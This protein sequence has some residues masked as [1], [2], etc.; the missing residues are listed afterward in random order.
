MRERYAELVERPDRIEDNLQ[1]GAVKAR[2]LS[3]PL[4]E[5]LRAAVGLRSVTV[6]VPDDHKS[7]GKKSKEKSARFVSFRDDA[8]QFRF[9]LLTRSEE[10]RV[11]KECVST[12]RF[13]WSPDHSKK[14]I[15]T[16]NY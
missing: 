12:C 7:A 14:N 11:G 8:G 10:R 6:C 9:R 15:Q 3:Q 4:M 1:A 2:R 5:R 13:R 16:V